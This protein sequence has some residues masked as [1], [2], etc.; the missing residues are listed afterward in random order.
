M[1]FDRYQ[2]T[3]VV[4]ALAAALAGCGGVL[5]GPPTSDQ[6]TPTAE[7]ETETQTVTATEAS[8]AGPRI[9]DLSFPNGVENGSINYTELRQN[10]IRSLNSQGYTYS[11][12]EVGDGRGRLY[13]VDNVT[14]DPGANVQRTRVARQVKP[15]NESWRNRTVESYWTE[16]GSYER[17]DDGNVTVRRGNETD[18]FIT[19]HDVG[20]GY[21]IGGG[22]Y[23]SVIRAFEWEATGA[24][25]RLGKDVLR[26]EST[27]MESGPIADNFTSDSHGTLQ[28]SEA[29]EVLYLELYLDSAAAGSIRTT[30]RV[31][32]LGNVTVS[33]PAW[34]ADGG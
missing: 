28:V 30:Y 16:N 32:E 21:G 3:L 33:E 13:F 25:T 7:A 31:H 27:A 5:G 23:G 1:D 20:S 9:A 29:G 14:S 18:D 17:D 4:V 2:W 24:T 8:P 26:F 19:V 6:V 34:T 11:E 22:N 12:V 10:H 15:E